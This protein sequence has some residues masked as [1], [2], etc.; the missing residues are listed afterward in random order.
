MSF[1][2]RANDGP[3]IV[4]SYYFSPQGQTTNKTT[5]THTH[6]H[7]H[8]EREREREKNAVIVGP[9]LAKLSRFAHEICIRAL[10]AAF[11][12]YILYI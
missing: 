7:T 5:H 6:T 10:L 12:L 3:H 4:V 8:R 11:F 1:R 9:P 2:W